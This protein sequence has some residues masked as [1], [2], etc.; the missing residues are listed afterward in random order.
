MATVNMQDQIKILIE[1]QQLDS[2]IFEKKEILD[3]VPEKLKE[4]DEALKQKS[5]TLKAH[6]EEL[7]KFQIAHK[8]K[9]V[10]LEAKEG[11]IK[12]HQAQLFLILL[13]VLRRYQI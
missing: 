5:S 9:E 7:K 8:E 1:L 13:Q 11:T 12:K 6:E 10:D 4:I 3:T 2:A